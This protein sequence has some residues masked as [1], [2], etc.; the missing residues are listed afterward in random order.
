MPE[1]TLRLDYIP[2]KV[3]TKQQK[4]MT[5]TEFINRFFITFHVYEKARGK[6]RAIAAI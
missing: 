5:T 1:A 6:K 3:T 4:K 2:F